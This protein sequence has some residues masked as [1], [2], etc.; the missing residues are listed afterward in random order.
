MLVA[1]NQPDVK[2]CDN[3][4]TRVAAQRTHRADLLEVHVLHAG[5]L[6]Q[7]AGMVDIGQELKLESHMPDGGII[8]S[9]GVDTDVLT[10]NSGA[11]ATIRAAERQARLVAE[12]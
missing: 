11:V 10:F 9:D 5:V 3:A 2:D 7:I 1:G 12:T 6:G 8:Y 4:L